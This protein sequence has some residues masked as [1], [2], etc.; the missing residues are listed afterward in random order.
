MFFLHMIA[1]FLVII[2]DNVAFTFQLIQCLLRAIAGQYVLNM[3]YV[4]GHGSTEIRE[5]HF[6]SWTRLQSSSGKN[7]L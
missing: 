1:V 6:L 7:V 4:L 2:I 3:C 5:A